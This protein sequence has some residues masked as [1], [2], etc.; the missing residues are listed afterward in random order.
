M[1]DTIIPNVQCVDKLKDGILVTFED[2]QCAVYSAFLLY[3]MLSQAQR[4]E[5][6]LLQETDD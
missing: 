3:T 5:S 2:G 1:R 6:D 4:V